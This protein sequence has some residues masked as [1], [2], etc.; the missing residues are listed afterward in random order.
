MEQ[1]NK[2][3]WKIL[4]L[5]VSVA[6]TAI[7]F[8]QNLNIQRENDRINHRLDVKQAYFNKGLIDGAKDRESAYFEMRFK[9][10]Q[11]LNHCRETKNACALPTE[12]SV[13]PAQRQFDS[14][15]ALLT[16]NKGE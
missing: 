14:L 2:W 15:E 3:M 1:Q 8:V 16:R 11:I 9:Y 5:V 4:F 7:I 13:L 10:E 6:M 12:L